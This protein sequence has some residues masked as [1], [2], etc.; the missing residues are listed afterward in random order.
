MSLMFGLIV[1]GSI[2]RTTGSGLACPDWPLCEGR[3]IPRFET[4]VL[5]EWFHRLLALL[6]SL[7]LFA[8]AFWVFVHKPVRARLGGLAG[9]AI[10]LLFVQVLLGALTVWKLLDPAVVSS[11]LAT[12]LLL[13]STLLTLGLVAGHLAA[14]PRRL[15]LARPAGL[16]PLFTIATLLVYA[17]AVLGGVVSTNGAG[18]ACPDWPTCRGE[19]FPPLQGL[20]AVHMAHRWTAYALGALLV[21]LAFRA[22][23]AP[24]ARV[25]RIARA[26]LGLALFQMLV[27]ILN[28]MLGIQ[29]W[30]SALHLANAAG[31]LAMSIVATFRLATQ[32]APHPALVAEATT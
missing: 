11:H 16:L 28:I 17:Q 2:V 1:V 14:P 7:L 27:G 25:A 13:F 15:P 30:V 3:L 5:L 8:T 26:L 4:H 32:P 23:T 19:W 24:D 20:V 9:L 12:G 31:M 6:V 22:R 21:V 10:A 29:V 18:I